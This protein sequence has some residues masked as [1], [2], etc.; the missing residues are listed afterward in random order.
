NL[1][2]SSTPKFFNNYDEDLQRRILYQQL[3]S[4]RMGEN[5]NHIA[6]EGRQWLG[7]P[8]QPRIPG[9][10]ETEINQQLAAAKHNA[11]SWMD[12]YNDG[13]LVHQSEKQGTRY[14]PKAPR[15]QRQQPQRRGK[16]L[17]WGETRQEPKGYN[18]VGQ[19][20]VDLQEEAIKRA[21]EMAR[22]RQE[23]REMKKR[24]V[25]AEETA[26]KAGVEMRRM[27]FGWDGL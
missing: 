2:T 18:D 5:R 22:L 1:F 15:P 8:N 26:R 6:H 19:F 3:P 14:F 9:L 16:K 23:N 13:Y 27:A 25:V 20:V 12:C 21:E 7:P 24:V 11:P 17:R 10:T 4:Q